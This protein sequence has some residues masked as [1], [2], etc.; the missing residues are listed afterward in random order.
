M[1]DISPPVPRIAGRHTRRVD[2]ASMIEVV[3]V[4]QNGAMLRCRS[5]LILVACLGAGAGCT[6]PSRPV[7][8]A[9]IPSASPTPVAAPVD[10]RGQL[11]V[12]V[13]AAEDRHYVASF[14]LTG[15]DGSRRTVTV[16]VARHDNWQVGIPGGAMS[17][18][19]DIAVARSG[20]SLYQCTLG[21]RASCVRVAGAGG[22]MP[23]RYD[24]R[25]QHMFSDWMDTLTDSSAALSVATAPRLSGARG[26]CYSVEWTSA[27]MAAPVD[28]GV[29]CYDTTGMLTAARVGFGTLLLVNGPASAPPSAPLPGPVVTRRPLPLVAPPTPTPSATP[30]ASASTR[31]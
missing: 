10:A 7:P 2:R 30:S 29:Y 13:A 20:D 15:T 3:P 23:A 8:V 9:D 17:G 31:A 11:A 19:T 12:R 14:R 1:Y 5:L 16:V 6:S 4:P 28:P 27:S 18:R 26:D 22:E 25:V 24:P 21:P